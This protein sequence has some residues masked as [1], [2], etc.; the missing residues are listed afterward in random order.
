MNPM[1]RLM[2]EYKEMTQHPVREFRAIPLEDNM[3]EW[4]FT[5]MGPPDSPYAG[6]L[7]HGKVIVPTNYPFAPPDVV[8]STPNGRFELEKKICL[9]ISS[10]HPE[11]WQSTWGVSTVLHALRQFMLTPGN[12]GI[13]AIEYPAETRVALAKDSVNYKCPYC[14]RTTAGDWEL[15]K[16]SPLATESDISAQVPPTPQM[17]PASSSNLM[18]TPT[19]SGM[20]APAASG[21]GSFAAARSSSFP[22]AP[23]S[24]ALAA[25]AAMAAAVAAPSSA[26]SSAAAAVIAAAG[27]T[28]DHVAAANGSS[29]LGAP[30][31]SPLSV[32]KPAIPLD[33][34][35]PPPMSGAEAIG[36]SAAAAAAST[37][38]TSP[39]ANGAEV[40]KENTPVTPAPAAAAAAQPPVILPRQQPR[41]AARVANNGI[42]IQLSLELLDKLVAFTALLLGLLITLKVA[43]S[44]ADPET[45][46]GRIFDNMVS[47]ALDQ[48][49]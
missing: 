48:L 24:P 36:T 15:M 47:S 49:E 26:T 10:Y 6:G 33:G 46:A 25:S 30:T 42:E 27:T 29:A 18:G 11:N 13:G 34:S 44:L 31:V 2:R 7:Y 39:T 19:Q 43:I 17:T 5:I 9:S 23:P 41:V 28:G 8:L 32:G 40:K 1:R 45:V 38:K 35:T 20:G 14:S 4:H 37:A 3:F 21:G 12:S 22:A 16:N